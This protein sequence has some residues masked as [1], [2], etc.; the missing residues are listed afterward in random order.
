MWI[1]EGAFRLLSLTEN[2]KPQDPAAAFSPELMD[3]YRRLQNARKEERA[4]LQHDLAKVF[5][6][7]H[8]LTDANLGDDYHL[9]FEDYAKARADFERESLR[10]SRLAIHVLREY[11]DENDVDADTQVANT[12]SN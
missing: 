8:D 1:K 7:E 4:A 5:A 11:L 12:R 3:L 2:M 10:V 9:Y 6:A